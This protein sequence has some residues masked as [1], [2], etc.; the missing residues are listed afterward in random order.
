MTLKDVCIILES[1]QDDSGKKRILKRNPEFVTYGTT[2]KVIRD[3]ASKIKQDDVLAIALFETNIYEAMMLASLI[4]PAEHMT[5]ELAITWVIKAN[6]SSIIDQGLSQLLLKTKNYTL[7]MKD[8]IIDADP[9]LR[10]AGF[11]ILSTYFRLENLEVIDVHFSVHTLEL[12]KTTLLNEPVTIQNAMNNA[13]VMAGLHVP[14]CVQKAKE[15]ADHIG[16]VMP[17]VAKNSC[18]IQSAS[19]YLVRYGNQP[20]FSRVAKLNRS[21]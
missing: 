5:K 6:Q 7:W 1:H 12:I 9:R 11:T 17:L 15:V 4:M 19:D 13:V 2:M 3:L 20:T 14:D 8:W 16:H 21:K 18:N 10:Y